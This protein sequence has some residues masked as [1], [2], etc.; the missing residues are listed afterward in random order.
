MVRFFNA[1]SL[2]IGTIESEVWK[3]RNHAA[4]GGNANQDNALNLIKGNKAL[5]IMVNRILLALGNGGDFYYD[6]YSLGR[7][8]IRLAEPIQDN[9]L[10]DLKS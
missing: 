8:T 9:Q 4:H 10:A 3:N 1:L 2:K 6:Y 5:L 7:P